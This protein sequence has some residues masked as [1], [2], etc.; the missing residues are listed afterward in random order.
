MGFHPITHSTT[1]LK[2]PHD[3]FPRT[4]QIQ[5]L[6]TQIMGQNPILRLS[7]RAFDDRTT[8]LRINSA[9]AY[10]AMD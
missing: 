7:E 8:P 1:L 5:T 4:K 10:I 2:H 6:I 9:C 3:L